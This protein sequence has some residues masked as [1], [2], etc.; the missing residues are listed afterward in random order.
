MTSGGIQELVQA[1]RPVHD[2]KRLQQGNVLVLV[3]DERDWRLLRFETLADKDHLV[4]VER[5]ENG[6]LTAR[7]EAFDYEIR[8]RSVRGTIDGSLF[9]AVDK[10]GL[11]T[12]VAVSLT[13]V[14]DCDID[15]HTE[16][17]STDT[18]Q[19]LVE[20]K[21]LDGQFVR[22]G[23]ILGARITSQGRPFWAFSFKGANGRA[24]YYDREGRSLRK[25]FLKSPLKYTRITS[26]F[27]HSRFHPVLQIYRPHLGVDYAAPTGT[28]VRAVAHGRISFAGWEGGFGNMVK[29]QHNGSLTS[30]YG[31][32]SRMAPGVHT[33]AS[34]SQ[35]QLI[36][37][38]GATGLATG[39][40]LDFR[41]VKNGQFIN[42]LK[43]N[44]LDGDP[45]PKD[46]MA[47]FRQMVAQRIGDMEKGSTA[48]A[49]VGTT[50][51][52]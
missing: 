3:Y 15:F 9:M 37:Y 13:E 25:A 11:P 30:M 45:V 4:I 17:R 19:I 26:G 36:G 29:I 22:F 31:H 28:P 20:E 32:L 34:V 1:L 38:V 40:H 41:L 35:G 42:P 14:F 46:Q 33:G 23:R 2:V 27:T 16:I 48:T 47:A 51:S 18:F 10:A 21:Y 7:K 52:R 49:M 50:A 39:P 6:L 24:E 44:T 12:S 5:G 8:T 43:V